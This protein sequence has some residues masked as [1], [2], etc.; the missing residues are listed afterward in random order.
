LILH[1]PVYLMGRFGA[2]LVKD[3]EETQA[4]N[5]VVFGLLSSFLL[6]PATFFFLW[7]LMWYT[8]LGAVV[9]AA[10]V[11]MF[12]NY[13]T[14]M[15]DKNYESGK[16]LLAAWRILVGVWAPKRWDLSISALS[17]YTTPPT[18]KENPW[19]KPKSSKNNS[20]ATS[21]PPSD[22]EDGP[23]NPRPRKRTPSRRLVRHVLRARVDAIKALSNF[24]DQ[25]QRSEQPTQLP[26]SVHLAKVYGITT[27]KGVD[28]V[29]GLPEYDG[30]REVH[31]VIDF[32][33]QR[34]AKIPRFK[35]AA[36]EAEWAA[37]TEPEGEGG[38]TTVDDS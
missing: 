11:Y 34:G 8:S 21:A 13:H 37:M 17:Q 7:A 31:E 26:A 1:L 2:G 24:F 35:Q 18:P 33:M 5:K 15:I 16:R 38:S 3:E 36:R 20:P 4:Q 19:V 32:L 10:T 9:S 30:S 25:L 22:S 29:T 6:Y 28:E 27:Q 23:V 14:L 12:A